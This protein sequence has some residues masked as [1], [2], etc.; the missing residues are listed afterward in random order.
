MMLM[1]LA[2]ASSDIICAC[3]SVGKPEYGSVVMSAGFNFP[4]RREIKFAPLRSTA[5]PASLNLSITARK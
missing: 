3:T 2:S 4:L 5:T 1:P